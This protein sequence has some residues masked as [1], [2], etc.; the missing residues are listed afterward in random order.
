[1]DDNKGNGGLGWDMV[2]FALAASAFAVNVFAKSD[3][4]RTQVSRRDSNPTVGVF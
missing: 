1:V 4:L 3:H 2:F